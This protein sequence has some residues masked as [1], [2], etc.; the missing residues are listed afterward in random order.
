[1]SELL[2]AALSYHKQGLSVIPLQAREKK[3]LIAWEKYQNE[4]GTEKEIKAWWSNWPEAN[5]GIV[6]GA[7]SGL[8]V[9]DLDTVEAK[10]KLG[11][12]GDRLL[13]LNNLGK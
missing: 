9:I 13:R 3:P 10:E 4:K 8:A 1:M 6:T 11:I 12:C 7:I 5:I 2:T